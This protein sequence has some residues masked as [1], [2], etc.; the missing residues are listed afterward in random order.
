MS[1]TII[2]GNFHSISHSG[3][4]IFKQPIVSGVGGVVIDLVSAPIPPGEHDL[5]VQAVVGGVEIYLPRYALFTIEGTAGIGGA[6][7]HDG[8]GFWGALSHKVKGALHLPSQ[9]PD[10]A[11]APIDPSQPVKIRLHITRG[12]GGLD[13]YRL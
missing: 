6:D 4:E 11:V 7:V 8:L 2:G 9:I 13:I 12:V 5:H 10:H 3:V 1:T